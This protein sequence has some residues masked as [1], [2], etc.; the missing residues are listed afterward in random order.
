MNVDRAMVALSELRISSAARE[1]LASRLQ[2]VR[3]GVDLATKSRKWKLR[4][5]LGDRVRWYEEPEEVA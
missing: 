1:V 4:A 5:R 2:T 3:A